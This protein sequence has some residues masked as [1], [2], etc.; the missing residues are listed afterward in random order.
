[1]NTIIGKSPSTWEIRDDEALKDFARKLQIP[2]D[3]EANSVGKIEV[4]AMYTM[5]NVHDIPILEM[6]TRI[7][8]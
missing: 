8:K 6:K 7:E 4:W 3:V 2:I 1:M 5:L